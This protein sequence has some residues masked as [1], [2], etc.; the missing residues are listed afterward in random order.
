MH[1][2]NTTISV[3]RDSYLANY[4]IVSDSTMRA[5]GPVLCGGFQEQITVVPEPKYIGPLLMGAIRVVLDS[6]SQSVHANAGL[7]RRLL[8]HRERRQSTDPRPESD[9]A[10]TKCEIG[11]SKVKTAGEVREWL[12]RAVSK[13]VEPL[14]VPW[15]RIPPSP[16]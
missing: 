1:L 12:N 7:K 10:R 16:P 2:R 15:V 9:A 8:L 3:D 11:Y 5:C 4:R 6:S 13:T 14:R